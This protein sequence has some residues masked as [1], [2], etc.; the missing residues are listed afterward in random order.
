MTGRHTG[1]AFVRGNT[2]VKPMGQIPLPAG[3]TTVAEVLQRAGY[4]TALVGKWGLGGPDS[5]GHPNKKGFD[6]FFGYLC[7]R[8]A[9]NYFPEFLFR[10]GERVELEGNTVPGDRPDGAGMAVERG[11]WVPDLMI[12]EALSFIRQNKEKPFFLYFATTIPHAN[13]E[14]GENG[15]EIP[16]DAPYSGEN[17]PQNERNFAAMVSRLDGDVGKIT[18]LLKELGLEQDTLV[19]F[20]SD[21]GPH[22]EG[23]HDSDFFDSNGPLRGTKRDLYEGGIRVPMIASR[24]GHIAS[25]RESAYPWAF[26]DFLPTAAAIAG[27]EPPA[28]LDGISVL[29]ELLGE[30]QPEHGPLYWEFHERGFAQAIRDG[31]WKAV[32]NGLNGPVELYNLRED[33]GETRDVAP[34]NQEIVSR[35]EKL[36]AE[37]RTESEQFPVRGT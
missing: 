32:R 35:M 12:G 3:E 10:N 16:S 23:G 5:E 33:L 18:A 1:H 2:E 14:A 25:G 6:H 21:N 20:T 9:H 22:R 11:T 36:F 8:H 29:P 24:P 7:Q 31:D 26:W 37:S 28:G 27:V 30:P 4:R 34:E 19:F 15:Q 17:W 13:N